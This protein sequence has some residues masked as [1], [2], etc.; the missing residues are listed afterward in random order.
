MRLSVITDEISQE[1]E[2]ALD[3]MGEYGVHG[4]ELRGL[5]GT[6]IG[7][8]SNAQ[9]TR[10]KEALAARG[11]T[12]SCLATPFYKCDLQDDEA[13]VA[14]R[15]H[16]ARARAYTEQMDLLRR[17]CEL[18][19]DFG[20]RLVRVFAFWRQGQLTPDVERRIIDAFEEP[21]RIAADAGIV[22]ALENE[23][24]CIL[25]TGAETA[26]VVRA[27]DS[28]TLR[29]CWDPGN[30]LAAGENPFPNGYDAIKDLLIHVHV[31]DAVMHDGQ[32]EWRVIGEGSI[33]YNGQ[34]AA[35]SADG[36]TGFVSLETHYVPEGGTSEEG[37]RACLS[38][39]R[40]FIKD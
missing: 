22:L 33:D 7:D 9:V 36:Y 24:A 37:S 26:R 38:A 1:F 13:V 5:W 20:T 15:M 4:A 31:K 2:H 27:I 16:L 39:L 29:V 40:G 3:V 19:H 12:V 17:C 23:H 34:M 18:A 32:P 30:A 35:L 6:N 25:G 21:V 10:A 14:G 28:P 11:M 8:L